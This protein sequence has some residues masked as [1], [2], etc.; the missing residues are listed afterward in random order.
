MDLRFRGC[1]FPVSIIVKIQSSVTSTLPARKLDALRK[2]NI[3]LP[4]LRHLRRVL[5]VVKI[6]DFNYFNLF[7]CA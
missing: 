6:H 3:A 7:M 5:I 1:I 4:L 2:Y